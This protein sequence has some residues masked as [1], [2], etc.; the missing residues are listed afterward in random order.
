MTKPAESVHV[1]K[2]LWVVTAGVEVNA[3]KM[4]AGRSVKDAIAAAAQ[5]L[6]KRYP[7]Q[8]SLSEARAGR[9]GR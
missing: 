6:K 4:R 2:S 9:V 1:A 7:N 8:R 3:V 5:V